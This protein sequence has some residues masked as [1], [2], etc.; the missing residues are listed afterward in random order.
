MVLT[1][2]PR[3]NRRSAGLRGLVRE[4]TL[5]PEHLVYPLFVQAGR[6]ERTP[7][8]SMPGQARLSVDLLV[9]TAAEA[10]G[11]GVPAVALFPALPNELKDPHGRESLNDAGLLQESVRALK[12]ALPELTVI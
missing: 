4:T 9:E 5:G 7:I 3:R 12:R 6:A 1:Q 2:R 11:L 8:A 10:F